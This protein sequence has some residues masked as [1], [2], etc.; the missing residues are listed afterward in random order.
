M[1]TLEY[2]LKVITTV[3]ALREARGIKQFEFAKVLGFSESY[4][5]KYEHGCKAFTTGQLKLIGKVMQ[6][7]HLQIIAIADV[8]D[9][10]NY[11]I[12]PL[13]NIIAKFVHMFDGHLKSVGLNEEELNILLDETKIIK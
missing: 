4:Y 2:D 5:S 8:Y 7:S 13:A 12:S 1:K 3:K 10:E 11:R 6:I 9:D